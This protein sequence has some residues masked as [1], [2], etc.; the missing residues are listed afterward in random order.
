MWVLGGQLF[1]ALGTL[2]GLRL[3]TE[4]AVPKVFGAVVL[5]TG[6]V[7]LIQNLFFLPLAQAALRHYGDSAASGNL[8]TMQRAYILCVS[9]VTALV[10]IGTLAVGFGIS[11]VLDWPLLSGPV[12]AAI[13]LSESVRGIEVT[14][15]NAA[16]RQRAYG[17]LI[18]T[19]GWMRPLG[20][21]A[22]ALI[23]PGSVVAILAGQ[24]M[25]VTVVAL[26]F[27]RTLDRSAR[28]CLWRFS[29]LDGPD[30]VVARSLRSYSRPLVPAALVSWVSGLADRYII[31]AVAGVAVAGVYSAGYSLVSKPFLI[32]G[33]TIEATLRQSLYDAVSRKDDASERRLLAIWGMIAGVT[34]SIGLIAIILFSDQITEIFLAKAY[35]SSTSV[36][37]WIAAGYVLFALSQAYERS[38]YAHGATKSVFAIQCVGAVA[39]VL[40]AAIGV[41]AAGIVGAA[42][43]VPAYFGLQLVVARYLSRDRKCAYKSTQDVK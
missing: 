20:S 8:E 13:M 40:F 5:A 43:A 38:C 1:S 14:L 24:L 12:L 3:L 42:I 35:A 41:W 16:R 18:A 23:V 27:S 32:L 28:N 10:A 26:V 25:S 30:A 36:M 7:A 19:D 2:I 15:L 33:A 21:V 29:K 17:T 31:T 6:G 34:G 4:V 39:S 9:R 11:I 22:G 37:P